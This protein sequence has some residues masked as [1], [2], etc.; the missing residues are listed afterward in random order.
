[1]LSCCA[2]DMRLMVLLIL[3]GEHYRTCLLL[4]NQIENILFVCVS[5]KNTKDMQCPS[6]RAWKTFIVNRLLDQIA[7]N[8]FR[9]FRLLSVCTAFVIPIYILSH[10]P[11]VYTIQDAKKKKYNIIR[12]YSNVQ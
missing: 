8:R 9:I 7:Q 10:Y 1:M 5:I 12:R 2:S 3:V 11:Y 4:A 6:T